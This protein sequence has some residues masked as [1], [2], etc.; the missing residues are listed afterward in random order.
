MTGWN[1][2]I[3]KDLGNSVTSGDSTKGM[4]QSVDSLN[5]ISTLTLAFLKCSA[6]RKTISYSDVKCKG[7]ADGKAT[8][9]A[10]GGTAEYS[11]KWLNGFGVEHTLNNIRSGNYYYSIQ[12]SKGCALNDCLSPLNDWTLC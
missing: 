12:D 2:S 6:F 11:Y 9:T 4:V 5:S 10:I 8:L 1:G 3:W 7:G